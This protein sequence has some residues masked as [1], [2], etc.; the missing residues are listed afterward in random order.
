VRFQ[1]QTACTATRSAMQPIR[2]VVVVVVVESSDNEDTRMSTKSPVASSR[3]FNV[4][5][6]ERR[7]RRTLIIRHEEDEIGRHAG[8]L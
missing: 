1:E 6:V 3:H 8:E 2:V 5:K 4:D 7:A